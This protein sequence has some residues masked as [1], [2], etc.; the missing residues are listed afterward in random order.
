MIDRG[1]VVRDPVFDLVMDLLGGDNPRLGGA[2]QGVTPELGCSELLGDGLNER[3]IAVE[4]LAV[5]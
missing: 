4:V 5:G 2:G 1:D 3:D